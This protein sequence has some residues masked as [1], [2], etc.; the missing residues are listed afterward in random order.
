MT[1]CMLIQNG[2]DQVC[3]GVNKCHC[4]I[5][6]LT[7]ARTYLNYCVLEASTAAIFLSN[8]LSPYL[9]TTSDDRHAWFYLYGLS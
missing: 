2:C 4:R 9:P 1:L 6:M 7:L 5:L 3:G 8:D